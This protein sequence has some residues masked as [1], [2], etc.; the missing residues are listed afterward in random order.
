MSVRILVAD[1]SASFGRVLK[2]TLE[3]ISGVEVAGLC[4]DGRTAVERMRRDMPDL[5]VVDMEMPEMNG[6]QVLETVRRERMKTSVVV[7]S[8]AGDRARELTM[9]AL[10]LGALD[11]ISKP[12][13]MLADVVAELR[14]RL[15]PLVQA[16]AHRRDV[17]NLLRR[18]PSAG[19]PAPPETLR[20]TPPPASG[21][22]A[23]PP[24]ADAQALAA[25]TS[26]LMGITAR[27]KPSMALIGVSTGGPEALGRVIPKLPAELRVPVLIVQHMPPLFT[28]NLA[29]KLDS[30]SALRVK[31]A[32]DGEIAT[33]GF[34]YIAPGGKHLKVTA[35]AQQQI[36]MR[37]TSDA[38]ENNCRPAVDYLFRSVAAAF[39]GRSIAVILTGMGRDGVAGLQALKTAGCPSI[40]QDEASCTVFGMPKEAIS[41][42]VID[43]IAPLDEISAEIAK[44]VR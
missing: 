32:E 33:A 22:A 30:C 26:R 25:A 3:T 13:M 37:L 24:P 1:D 4:R 34:V 35:G 18:D 21:K 10:D 41:A 28:Q 43:T 15:A 42:G 8:S 2:Q 17:Q 31:E 27:T 29:A 44:A 38:P 19:R 40:A 23:T 39:P 16:A 14:A 5:L 20:L 9:R 12:E 11:F 36:V 7:V 6:I